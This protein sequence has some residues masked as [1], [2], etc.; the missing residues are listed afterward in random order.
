MGVRVVRTRKGAR[1]EQD[2]LILS[3]VLSEPGPTHTL[4]DV[5]AA[6]IASL[7]TGT[8]TALL[9][10]AAGGIIAPL[11]AMGFAHPI[12]S[13]DLSVE[14]VPLFRELSEPWCGQVTVAEEDAVRW[15][16]RHRGPFDQILEDL[17]ARVDGEITKPRVCLDV[18]PRLMAARIGPRGLAFTNV[19]PVPGIP[20]TRLLADL[21]APFERAAFLEL[22]EWENR[23]L[24]AGPG[25]PAPRE[26]GRT[27]RRHLDAIGSSEADGLSVHGLR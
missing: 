14:Q 13:V 18:L 6:T 27:L 2:G 22:E 20:F 24:L 10:F 8:R 23:V 21:A 11:R 26:I 17:S 15:L 1:L 19:L 25:L 16:K 12:E 9:G 7:G 5:L 4:F 3:E